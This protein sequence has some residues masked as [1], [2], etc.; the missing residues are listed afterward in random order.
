MIKTEFLLG[1]ELCICIMLQN[2]TCNL[3][4]KNQK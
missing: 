1:E 3:I 2:K 4:G